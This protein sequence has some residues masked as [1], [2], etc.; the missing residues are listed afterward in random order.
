MLVLRA[1]SVDGL[2]RDTLHSPSGLPVAGEREVLRDEERRREEPMAI[3][4]VAAAAMPLRFSSSWYTSTVALLVGWGA[5]S[6]AGRRS[7]PP[8]VWGKIERPA[9][10]PTVLCCPYWDTLVIQLYMLMHAAPTQQQCMWSPGL[11]S[12][13]SPNNARS[14]YTH[15]RDRQPRPLQHYTEDSPG[16]L[17]TYKETYEKHD[18]QTERTTPRRLGGEG[19]V[20]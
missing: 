13:L 4:K 9:F 2:H 17:W 14:E 8:A 20:T 18:S 11:Q 10:L 19:R 6:P 15:T 3:A 12:W 16:R 7:A 5:P 1:S